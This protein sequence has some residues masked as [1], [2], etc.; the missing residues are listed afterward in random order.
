MTPLSQQSNCFNLLS[1]LQGQPKAM[2]Q[3][4]W[5]RHWACAVDIFELLTTDVTAGDLKLFAGSKYNA[6]S[7]IKTLLDTFMT[8]RCMA[9]VA[10]C[11]ALHGT[12]SYRWQY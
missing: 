1:L 2:Q 7:N 9:G 10:L 5:A 8:V 4:H 6:D 11:M 3:S 12:A